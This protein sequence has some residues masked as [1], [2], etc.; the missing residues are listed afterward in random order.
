VGIG[1][2]MFLI[3]VGA[4]LTFA[5]EKEAEGIDLNTVGVILMIIGG[6]GLVLSLLM[7]DRIGSYGIRRRTVVQRGD[8][9]IVDRD[10]QLL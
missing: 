4:I 2:S 1:V 8:G 7:W 10:D 6:I 3:A 9:A 5:V